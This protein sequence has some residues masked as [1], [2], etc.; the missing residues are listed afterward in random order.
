M[1]DVELYFWLSVMLTTFQSVIVYPPALTHLSPLAALQA[2]FQLRT[3]GWQGLD[4]TPP[5]SLS[6]SG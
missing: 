3:K 2:K 1:P 5:I 4:V 6:A